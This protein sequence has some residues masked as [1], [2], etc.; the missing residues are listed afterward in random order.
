MADT[1]LYDATYALTQLLRTQAMSGTSSKPVEA[2]HALSQAI[3]AAPTVGVAAPSP[4]GAQAGSPT[5]THSF[6]V[7]PLT[8][9]KDQ[10]KGQQ[11][12]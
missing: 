3:S 12:K 6:R 2:T 4:I 8:A 5:P 1:P 11:Q 9:P 7:E 10:K